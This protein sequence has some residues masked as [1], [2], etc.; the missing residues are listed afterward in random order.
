MHDAVERY[1]ELCEGGCSGQF[2][3]RIQRI[4]G[5]DFT[6]Q[7]PPRSVVPFAAALKTS[8]AVYHSDVPSA[9][10][11]LSRAA[12][13]VAASR[14]AAE[15]QQQEAALAAA[16]TCVYPAAGGWQQP[17]GGAGPLQLHALAA[18]APAFP[19]LLP[20]DPGPLHLDLGLGF[21]GNTLMDTAD[22][23]QMP[24]E[25]EVGLS[26]DLA[27]AVLWPPGPSLPVGIAGLYPLGVGARCPCPCHAV[28]GALRQLHPFQACC[29][30]GA[31]C[32]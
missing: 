6:Y 25:E 27:R 2:V 17:Q 21:P 16:A 10:A 15:A 29:C 23:T 8:T 18:P 24:N 1:K 20:P 31:C 7:P 4:H 12:Q 13:I 14:A 9:E 28:P 5:V 26:S 22:V 32:S 11:V 30:G 19:A 3:S